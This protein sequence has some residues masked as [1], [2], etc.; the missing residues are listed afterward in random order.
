[1]PIR[2]VL[3]PTDFTPLSDCAV[4]LATRICQWYGAS[5][6]LEHNLDARPP[7]FLSVEW[8]VGGAEGRGRERRSARRRSGCGADVERLASGFRA[9]RASRA[10]R[11][12]SV[13]WR[14]RG[15]FRSSSW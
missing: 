9:R 13:S 11:S 3:C 1:M 15:H 10:A 6:V 8:M 7:S 5:L 4:S 14:W 12:S 2:T